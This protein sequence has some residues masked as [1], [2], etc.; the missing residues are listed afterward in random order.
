MDWATEEW[1]NLTDQV[2][3]DPDRAIRSLFQDGFLIKVKTGV[4]RYEPGAVGRPLDNFTENQKRLIFE[5]DGHKCVICGKGRKEG[6]VLH[7]DHIRPR[8]QGGRSTIENGQT[9]C[10]QH[11]MYKATLKQTETGKKMF[12]RFYELAKFQ[13]NE[14]LQDFC[15]DILE[16]YDKHDMN[17]HIRWDE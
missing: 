14:R 2:F 1:K 7:A 6:M 17:S 12:I 9:L 10:S 8:D 16:T 3:R 13:G 5:R 11:N 15:K 4:Y